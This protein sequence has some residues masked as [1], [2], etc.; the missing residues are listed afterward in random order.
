MQIPDIIIRQENNI[1]NEMAKVFHVGPD[2]SNCSITIFQ[3]IDCMGNIRESSVLNV[4]ENL[5]EITTEFYR[6]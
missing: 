2:F 1:K 4:E 5:C 6:K 3:Q